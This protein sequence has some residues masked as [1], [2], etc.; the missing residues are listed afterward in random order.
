MLFQDATS[1]SHEIVVWLRVI[2]AA[3]TANGI[4][5]FIGYLTT[6]LFRF[7]FYALQQSICAMLGINNIL[8]CGTW[9]RQ[10]MLTYDVQ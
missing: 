10:V 3:E 4:A 6:D 5:I 2:I 9:K 1:R 7:I 8:H